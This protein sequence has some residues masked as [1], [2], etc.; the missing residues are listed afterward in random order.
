MDP[1]MQNSHLWVSRFLFKRDDKA[2][3]VIIWLAY[4]Q[5]KVQQEVFM[6]FRVVTH[7]DLFSRKRQSL[8]VIIQKFINKT[9]SFLAVH[10]ESCGGFV[11]SIF[12]VFERFVGE[13]NF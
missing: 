1:R 11:W 7:A 9:T 12:F 13:N 10:A 2:R 8:I 4:S 5:N 3:N 6:H